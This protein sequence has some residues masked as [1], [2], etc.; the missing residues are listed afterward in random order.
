MPPCHPDAPVSSTLIAYQ[1]I[2]AEDKRY[3]H[4]DCGKAFR[5]CAHFTQLL[6]IHTGR[7]FMYVMNGVKPPVRHQ[8]SPDVTLDSSPE[9]TLERSSTDVAVVGKLLAIIY[10]LLYMRIHSEE[11]PHK[12]NEC[13]EGIQEF[14]RFCHTSENP[15]WRE[16]L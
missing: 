4:T 6:R 16:T 7:N 12:C 2:H 8:N 1:Q 3:E 15:Y 10:T 13:W 9:V 11:R 5:K 14:P